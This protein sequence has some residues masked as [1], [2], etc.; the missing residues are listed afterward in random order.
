MLSFSGEKWVLASDMATNWLQ[1]FNLPAYFITFKMETDR[2]QVGVLILNKSDAED[3]GFL[4]GTK[5]DTDQK[6]NKQH[7]RRA[8]PYT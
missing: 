2:V 7:S 3:Y 6:T 5:Y 1:A 4:V 8:T